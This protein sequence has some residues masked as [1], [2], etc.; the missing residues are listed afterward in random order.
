MARPQPDC[1]P[2]EPE[3]LGTG[4]RALPSRE[5]VRIAGAA[6][7]PAAGRHGGMAAGLTETGNLNV[8]CSLSMFEPPGK[9]VTRQHTKAV[10]V[11]LPDRA[12]NSQ[13]SRPF[14]TLLYT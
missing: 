12:T 6:R 8:S 13:G 14:S 2:L 1:S 5:G 9:A 10:G 3:P 4:D 11:K 7:C